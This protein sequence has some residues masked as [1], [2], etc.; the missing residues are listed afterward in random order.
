MSRPAGKW[1]SYACTD[2]QLMLA[3]AK[4]FGRMNAAGEQPA[5]ERWTSNKSYF[6]VLK[7]RVHE[8]WSRICGLDH[9]LF[10]YRADFVRW[11]WMTF[12]K[13]SSGEVGKWAKGAVPQQS[14]FEEIENVEADRRG[15]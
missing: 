11:A 2:R 13:D 4:V 14:L 8:E 9:C 7:K 3:V 15:G 12:R 1:F 5:A 6:R 10:P